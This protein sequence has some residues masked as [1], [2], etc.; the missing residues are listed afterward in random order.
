MTPTIRG[1]WCEV[2][3]GRVDDGVEPEASCRITGLI[4]LSDHEAA[5]REAEKFSLTLD[6]VEDLVQGAV[7][8]ERERCANLAESFREIK[9]QT[10]P[11]MKDTVRYLLTT[12]AARIREGR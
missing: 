2:H 8:A 9:L 11:L 6:N 4:T 10:S 12:L 1:R 7:A 5:M 3:G